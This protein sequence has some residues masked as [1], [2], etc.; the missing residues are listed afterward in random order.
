MTKYATKNPL[1]STSPYDLFDNA[2]NF[3]IAVNSIT[4]AIWN[5]RFGKRRM[6]WYGIESLATQSMLNYGYITAKSFELG[7]TLNTPNTVLQWES[8]GEY[9]RWD[10][11]WSSPKVVPPGSTPESS[12]GI[13]PGKWVSVGDAA[14]R[15]YV[16]RGL[17][18]NDIIPG[19]FADNLDDVA[20]GTLL[21]VSSYIRVNGAVYR[22]S[23][24]AGGVVTE[25]TA[26]YIVA[27]GVKSYLS[28]I[29]RHVSGTHKP[30]NWKLEF[31]VNDDNITADLKAEFGYT[32]MG[33]Q[34]LHIDRYDNLVYIGWQTL[35][36][37]SVWVTVHDWITGELVTRLHF[38][39]NVGAPEGIHVY[40]VSGQRY[41]LLPY[42]PNRT[43][44]TYA[45]ADPRTLT[46]KTQ[47]TEFKESPDLGVRYQLSGWANTLLYENAD[48]GWPKIFNVETGVSNIFNS[49]SI[50]ALING[51]YSPRGT[52]TVG[53][54]VVGRGAGKPKRQGIALGSQRIF[55][56]A[57]ASTTAA[58]GWSFAGLQGYAEY[59]LDGTEVGQYLITPADFKSYWDRYTGLNTY[60]TENEGIQSCDIAGAE[61]QYLLQSVRY[62]SADN[63]NY[64]TLNIIR[65]NCP[66]NEP[67]TI[68]L[69]QRAS[70]A[71]QIYNPRGR[72][73]NAGRYHVNPADGVALFSSVQVIAEYLRATDVG[74]Y[75]C[76]LESDLPFFEGGASAPGQV[77]VPAYNHIRIEYVNGDTWNVTVTGTNREQN[78]TA[79]I[80]KNGG[81]NTVA[82]IGGRSISIRGSAGLVDVSVRSPTALTLPT[83]VGDW[84]TGISTGAMGGTSVWQ[85]TGT[86]NG[87]LWESGYSTT[88][89]LQVFMSSTSRLFFRYAGDAIRDGN[90]GWAEAWSTLNTTVDS[91]GFIK[92]ASPVVKIFTDGRSETNR[93]SEGVTVTRED[94]GIYLITGCVGLNADPAWGGIDGGFEIPCD[95]NKQPLVWLD[96]E[97]NGDGSVRVKTYHRTHPAAPVFAQNNIEGIENGDPV[98]I[99]ADQFVSVRVEMP[100][101][102]M[103]SQT[104]KDLETQLV[105]DDSS[106]TLQ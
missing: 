40:R 70:S 34:G 99:P 76:Y 17:F 29:S 35:N 91:S 69:S 79:R 37:G 2:Q 33:F 89:A 102:S 54:G 36:P 39:N 83:F 18:L 53:S 41:I 63:T 77:T 103:W 86:G 59:G 55:A 8:N 58:T 96:Y 42:S 1:G 100:D 5:D 28:H 82:K 95:R 94:V 92:K 43:I 57:G 47:V 56:G 105:D 87:A 73:L 27:D 23:P 9:Y 12:G 74:E 38:P 78:Y 71:A 11:G 26:R 13:G 45:I 44:R 106:E 19:S 80:T 51:T 52:I 62:I 32:V 97:V 93:E 50:T 25:V 85:P 84:S 66:V 81:Y 90:T 24:A 30:L 31:S 49:V 3:D 98:D 4:A 48:L 10:G 88:R 101:D 20:V 104:L 75:T 68:D 22:C 15:K 67:G 6:S 61:E 46:D 21:P 7:A 60:S 14:L 64:R 65:V 72:N 16:K